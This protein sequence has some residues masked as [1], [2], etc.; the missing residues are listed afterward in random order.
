MLIS[1][2]FS[3]IILSD[4]VGWVPNLFEH[5]WAGYLLLLLDGWGHTWYDTRV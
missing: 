1:K 3:R 5:G 4:M 2:L